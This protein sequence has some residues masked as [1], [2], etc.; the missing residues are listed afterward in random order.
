[1]IQYDALHKNRWQFVVHHRRFI[2]RELADKEKEELQSKTNQEVLS[3]NPAKMK[4]FAVRSFEYMI[5]EETPR[6]YVARIGRSQF[7]GTPTT[8][9]KSL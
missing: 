6:Y 7:S 9:F 2:S 5:V 1:M 3:G 8:V 4:N